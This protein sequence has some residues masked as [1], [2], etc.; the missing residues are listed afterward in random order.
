MMKSLMGF[1]FLGAYVTVGIVSDASAGDFEIVRTVD[2][3]FCLSQF[4]EYEAAKGGDWAAHDSL[5]S[6]PGGNPEILI[7]STSKDKAGNLAVDALYAFSSGAPE[8]VRIRCT[9]NKSTLS[10]S[11][12]F[13]KRVEVQMAKLALENDPE[14]QRQQREKKRE[15]ARQERE[16]KERAAAKHEEANKVHAPKIK[17]M[18]EKCWDF[19]VSGTWPVRIVVRDGRIIRADKL[20]K[21]TNR[22]DLINAIRVENRLERVSYKCTGLPVEG[23]IVVHLAPTRRDNR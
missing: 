17:E 2:Y 20:G 10:F 7:T 4:K 15:I 5:A 3:R 14:Y 18:I 12:A 13:L 1:A 16:A 21:Q 8:I 22:D 19:N 9:P 11:R 23:P 6:L